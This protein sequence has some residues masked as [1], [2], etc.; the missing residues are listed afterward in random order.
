MKNLLR[1][2]TCFAL[3]LAS[4]FCGSLQAQVNATS[5][6]SQTVDAV[7]CSGTGSFTL[8]ASNDAGGGLLYDANEYEWVYFTGG[9]T[10]L[11]ETTNELTVN[12]L[13]PGYHTYKVRGTVTS[14]ATCPGDFQEYTIYVLPALIVTIASSGTANGNT[15]CS[16]NLPATVQLTATVTPATPVSEAFGYNYQWFKDVGGIETALTGETSPVY[17]VT[18]FALGNATYKIKATYK[19]LNSC[20]YDSSANSSGTVQIVIRPKPIKPV[21]AFTIN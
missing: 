16:D 11:S 4:L 6:F 10:T 21:V 18:D 19:V 13:S 3:L 15:F 20:S 2:I 5:G 8:T 14:A 9:N 12:N 7:L 1:S 17:S